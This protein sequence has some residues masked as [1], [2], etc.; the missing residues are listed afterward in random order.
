MTGDVG[1]YLACSVEGCERNAHPKAWGA[2]GCCVSHYQRLKRHGDPLKGRRQEGEIDEWI[3]KLIEA[4]PVDCVPWPFHRSDKGYGLIFK[5]QASTTASRFICK[6]V[7]GEPPTPEHEAAHS[8]GKGHTGCV[9]PRHLEWK[10]HAENIA[11]KLEHGT[12]VQGEDHPFAKLSA[13]AVLEIRNSDEK[14]KVLAA[15]YGVSE[16]VISRVRRGLTW[17]SIQ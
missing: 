5:D 14:L 9:T 15:R 4:D 17:K 11:D 1:T 16:A 10:T 3:E 12:S 7:H 6:K 2:R 13:S 8:C